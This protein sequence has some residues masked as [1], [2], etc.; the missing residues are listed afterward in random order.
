MPDERQLKNSLDSATLLKILKGALI[1][2]GGVAAIYILEMIPTLEF[3]AY[4]A[5]VTGICAVLI[6]AI[7]EYKKGE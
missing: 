4:T 1:A 6:N 7:R 3:G 5:L 2:G